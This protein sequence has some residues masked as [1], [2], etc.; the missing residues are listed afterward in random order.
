MRHYNDSGNT[1]EHLANCNITSDKGMHR[2]Y[3]PDSLEIRVLSLMS[4]FF[5]FFSIFCLVWATKS[6]LFKY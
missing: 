6:E 5:F 2:F 4:V 3:T 1:V